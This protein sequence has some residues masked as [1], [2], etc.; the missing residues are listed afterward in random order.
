MT[1]R[2][3]FE[4]A[5]DKQKVCLTIDDVRYSGY[6]YEDHMLNLLYRYA[7]RPVDVT[8]DEDTLLVARVRRY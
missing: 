2:G 7:E 4:T 8:R 6:W 3:L 5:V 1:L